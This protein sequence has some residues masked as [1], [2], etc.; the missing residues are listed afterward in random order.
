MVPIKLTAVVLTGVLFSRLVPPDG[1]HEVPPSHA[2]H[3]DTGYRVMDSTLAVT[4]F[5]SAWRTI[6]ATF[7]GRGVTRLD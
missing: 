7:E 3:S 5:D 1:R 6:G 2:I 4:T